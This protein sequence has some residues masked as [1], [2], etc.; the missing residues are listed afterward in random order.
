MVELEIEL[1]ARIP[2]DYYEYYTSFTR[3]LLSPIQKAG[4]PIPRRTRQVNLA[5]SP[6][7]PRLSYIDANANAMPSQNGSSSDPSHSFIGLARTM[8]QKVHDLGSR[9]YGG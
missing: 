9:R 5:R 2:R 6:N 3:S 1:T 7:L 8:V 4:T